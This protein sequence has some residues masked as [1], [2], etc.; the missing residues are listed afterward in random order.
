MGSRMRRLIELAVL[1]L[2]TAPVLEAA[3]QSAD[4]AM[5]A[6]AEAMSASRRDEFG[7][8]LVQLDD[9]RDRLSPVQQQRLLILHALDE[10]LNGGYQAA[11]GQLQAV[12]DKA[13][14]PDVKFRAGTL[15]ARLYALDRQFQKGLE[16]LAGVLPLEQQV[17]SPAMRHLGWAAASALYNAMGVSDLARDYAGKLLA[18]APTPRERCLGQAELLR[19][20]QGLGEV[21]GEG[22]IRQ[23]IDLCAGQGD[24]VMAARASAQLAR[25]L[26]DRGEPDKAVALLRD[27][28]P[29]LQAIG[30]PRLVGEYQ[31]LLGKY[32]LERGANDQAEQFA[33]AAVPLSTGLPGS[34]QLV[35]AYQTLYRVAE[36][37]GNAALA[38]RYYR[39]YAEADRAHLSEVRA[40]ETAYQLVSQQTASKSQQIA[41]LGQQ[42]RVLQLRQALDRE[43]SRNAWLVAALAGLLAC[44]AAYW[45]LRTR[46]VQQ[47]LRVSAE[48]DSLTRLNNRDAFIRMAHERLAQAAREGG[49]AA[50]VVFDLDHVSSINERFGRS[51]GDWVLRAVADTVSALAGEADCLARMGGQEFAV[52]LPGQDMR[53]GGRLAEQMR[54]HVAAMSTL[55]SGYSFVVTASFG[56]A[57]SRDSGYDLARLMSDADRAMYDAKRQ[58]R[59]RVR[60]FAEAAGAGAVHDSA[61]VVPLHGEGAGR[62]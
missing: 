42:N 45:A 26:H 48:T 31:A 56:L 22:P 58:G 52:L 46:R 39:L 40:R 32:L 8:L 37:R 53:Q 7:L 18:D 30:Y 2:A 25:W 20:R 41:L 43:S 29:A 47:A 14:D 59:N 6:R 49:D 10:N 19:A 60:M 36:S 34:E 57:G 1:V 16:V 50:L 4:E 13:T 24:Q 21:L 44:M 55:G 28:L 23:V 35:S 17:K 33:R 62:H 15:L 3:A 61:N 54:A 51:T 5:L 9:A 11:S 27:G 12:L 38:L